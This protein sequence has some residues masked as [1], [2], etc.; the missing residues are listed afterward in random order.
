LGVPLTIEVAY[1][2]AAGLL[3]DYRS[4]LALGG[5]FLDGAA[6]EGL[7]PGGEATLVLLVDGVTP[8][9]VAAQVTTADAD[10]ICLDVTPD[11]A[12]KQ[13]I[14]R[15]CDGA[16]PGGSTKRRSVRFVVAH[17][18][19]EPAREPAAPTLTLERK[20]A[21]LSVGEKIRLAQHGTREERIW[22][23]KDRAGV[24]QASLVRNP[25]FTI[26][27]VLALARA[28][29]LAPDAAEA[30]AEHPTHGTSTQLALA[31][32]R[33]PRTPIPL[34]IEMVGKL[35]PSDLRT[36]AKG[37]GVRSQVAQAARKKLLGA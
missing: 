2:S 33:N 8:L 36:L 7:A 34:A 16:D 4:Q 30:M 21:M 3:A 37:L 27:E 20:I 31:L 6:P 14:A 12:L 15:A 28:P 10:S 29:H 35:Q 23:A 11:E 13:T 24:V 17:A 9:R 5:L 32:A 19:D 26:D 18:S 25:R 22:L 1:E